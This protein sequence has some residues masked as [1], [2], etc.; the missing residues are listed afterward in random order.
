MPLSHWPHLLVCAVTVTP[1]GGLTGKQTI[2]AMQ[3]IKT[4]NGL[5]LFIIRRALTGLL[6]VPQENYPLYKQMSAPSH[7][8]H[9]AGEPT[10]W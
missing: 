2:T 6:A 5:L 4:G 3:P 10:K 7:G 1:G 9:G 8:A